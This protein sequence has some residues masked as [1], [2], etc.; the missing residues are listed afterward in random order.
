[1]ALPAGVDRDNKIHSINAF[2]AQGRTTENF[3]T[4]LQDE[5]VAEQYESEYIQLVGHGIVDGEQKTL[6]KDPYTGYW[7]RFGVGFMRIL[8]I[9]SQI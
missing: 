3:E 7:K 9:E 2:F 4:H 5:F 6:Y 1:L 8:P